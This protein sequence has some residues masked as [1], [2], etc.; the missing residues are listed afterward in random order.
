M[1]KKDYW[2]QNVGRKMRQKGT[3]GAFTEKAKRAGMETQAF[4]R[5]VKA[6]PEKFSQETWDQAHFAQN[7]GKIAKKRK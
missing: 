7:A 3:V 2:M 4:A 1:P 6:H 5:H